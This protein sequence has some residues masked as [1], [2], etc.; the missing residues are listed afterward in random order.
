MR[1]IYIPKEVRKPIQESFIADE[2]KLTREQEQETA[3]AE[4]AFAEAQKQ[5]DLERERVDVDTTRQFETKLAD[6]D[7][8]AKGIDAET[9]RLVAAI[10]KDTAILEANAVE[11]LGEAENKGKQLVEEAKAGRFKLA[12]EAFGTP[13][14][15]NNWI[16]ATGLP[17]D[18]DLKL[19]YAGEGTLWTDMKD[20]GV[21]A[22]IP[23]GK[24]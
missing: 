6:G 10:E 23:V 20:V 18:V 24:K 17:E 13:A 21:R 4:A 11:I 3:K 8:Q 12:V 15:Y 22:T 2:L 14:A 7:R 1:H 9:E 19:L 16:F 5:V